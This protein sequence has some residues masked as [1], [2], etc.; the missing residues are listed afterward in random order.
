MFSR[1][2]NIQK[3]KMKSVKTHADC[4]T[5]EE[6][7]PDQRILIPTIKQIFSPKDGT[8]LN[9]EALRQQHLSL[10][11]RY[12]PSSRFDK[13]KNFVCC[14]V[15]QLYALTESYKPDAP[16]NSR[17]SCMS[18]IAKLNDGNFYPTTAAIDPY[19]RA[20]LLGK[21]DEGNIEIKEIESEEELPRGLPKPSRRVFLMKKGMNKPGTIVNFPIETFSKWLAEQEG[22][23]VI[24]LLEYASLK[25]R[26]SE[27]K[28]LRIPLRELDDQQLTNI[29]LEVLKNTTGPYQLPAD[30][31]R[32][33]KEHILG[34]IISSLGFQ[35]ASWAE[36]IWIVVTGNEVYNKNRK[37]YE[38]SS[39]TASANCYTTPVYVDSSVVTKYWVK[40][41]EGLTRGDKESVPPPKKRPIGD[42]TIY[43]SD[44]KQ[45]KEERTLQEIGDGILRMN[46]LA[47]QVLSQRGDSRRGILIEEVA[48]LAEELMLTVSAVQMQNDEQL[49]R[50]KQEKNH[51]EK[52]LEYSRRL[53]SGYENDLSQMQNTL[54]QVEKENKDLEKQLKEASS[55]QSQENSE[56]LTENAA[57]QEQLEKSLQEKLAVIENMKKEKSL[58]EEQFSKL[59]NEMS[60]SLAMKES[61][62]AMDIS[63]TNSV[64]KN[65][66]QLEKNLKQS[67][68][69]LKFALNNASFMDDSDDEE[70]FGTPERTMAKNTM[71][72]ITAMT[73]STP[74]KLGLTKWDPNLMNFS[75]WFSSM[76]MPIEG[77][78]SQSGNNEKQIIRLVLMCL[79]H[80]YS[81]VVNSIADD[82]QI[83]TIEKAKKAILK[84]IYGERGLME[85]FF[86]M[87][88]HQSEHP[89]TFLTRC[90]SNLESTEDMDSA[91][92]LKAIE[93]KL[94]K[95]LD[96]ATKVEL[97]RILAN[98]DRKNLTFQKLK[99]ALQKAI[100]LTGN[101]QDK[102]NGKDEILSAINAIQR[103]LNRCYICDSTD[104]FASQCNK[105]YSKSK[106]GT[107]KPKE[108]FRRES[109]DKKDGNCF[110]CKQPG[111]WKNNC[112]LR[113]ERQANG[114]NRKF[115]QT[116]K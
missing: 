9:L 56:R 15:N 45:L 81:W 50:I 43:E 80:K 11:S 18:L 54:E 51:V 3:E 33:E 85:D 88:M 27:L 23:N 77:A 28:L 5:V 89:M 102:S 31:S 58:L 37:S 99:D 19:F 100:T 34:K 26:F 110:Y 52:Q 1:L 22:R 55:S 57:R 71:N 60:Q 69:P 48:E 105:H 64:K 74:Q 16:K 38:D 20:P 46:E 108:G 96:R 84:M 76:R 104:H 32:S 70:E 113:K 115:Q 75:E 53:I 94:I 73:F 42:C 49:D 111:H 83:N 90:Q 8:R 25:N 95:F 87:K 17:R 63:L 30:K 66:K 101:E 72:S 14:P 6:D 59:N 2:R 12:E 61:I 78:Q 86:D 98:E 93:E 67:G 68:S 92:V 112:K 35:E 107:F 21:Y 36:S 97:Q 7:R 106:R 10:L 91:F 79:P 13:D 82:T 65:N 114:K 116:R 41:P 109:K 39:K 24:S 44:N 62:S 40:M 103:R 29:V 4:V 47:G